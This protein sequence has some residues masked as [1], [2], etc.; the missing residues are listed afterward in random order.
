LAL[1]RGEFRV[2]GGQGAELCDFSLSWLNA[3]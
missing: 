3:E 1:H 2:G